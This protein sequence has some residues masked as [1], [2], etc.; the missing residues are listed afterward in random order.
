M[1][2]ARAEIIG[3]LGRDAELRFTPAGKPVCQFSVAV[4]IY[5]GKDEAGNAKE[6]TQWFRAT[7]WGAR[8]ETLAER[9]TKGTLVYV[10]GDFKMRSW[11][12]SDG[13]PRTEPEINVDKVSFLSA[14]KAEGDEPPF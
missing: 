6:E 11:E 7:L 9:L 8:A 1:S 4:D 2:I 14:K 10:C 12:G 5:A 13:L 3:R